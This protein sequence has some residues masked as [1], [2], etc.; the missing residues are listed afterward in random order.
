MDTSYDLTYWRGTT[1]MSSVIH[2]SLTP[3]LIQLLIIWTLLFF[4]SIS[5]LL[6]PLFLSCNTLQPA[7]VLNS[8]VAFK[9]GFDSTTSVSLSAA[10]IN[11]Y[12]CILLNSTFF[13]QVL[14][15]VYHDGGGSAG[16]YRKHRGEGGPAPQDHPIGSR[17][18]KQPGQHVW[19][20]CCDE[21]AGAATS[22]R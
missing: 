5:S 17:V 7:T 16:L 15:H 6:F 13:S 12:W 22:K 21:S 1:T 20:C 14:Y 3:T 19:L 10:A 18:E 2:H 8:G 9:I 11:F 4:S